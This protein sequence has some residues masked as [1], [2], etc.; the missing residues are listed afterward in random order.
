[1]IFFSFSGW[2]APAQ[3]DPCTGECWCVHIK[4]HEIP[5]TRKHGRVRCW[6]QPSE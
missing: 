5:N 1:M 2:F 6:R 3:C 4:G